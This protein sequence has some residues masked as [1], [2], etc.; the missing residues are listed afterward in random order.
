MNLTPAKKARAGY[1]YGY[2][3]GYAPHEASA[4]RDAKKDKDVGRT[5]GG[6]RRRD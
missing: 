6:H 5:R 1:G 4:K 2:G 3:Y